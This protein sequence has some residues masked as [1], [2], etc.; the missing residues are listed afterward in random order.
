MASWTAFAT[1]APAASCEGMRGKGVRGRGFYKWVAPYLSPLRSLLRE[2]PFVGLL[3]G[4]RSGHSIPFL[5]SPDQLILL[6]G[7]SF[8]VI[9]GEFSPA[10]AGRAGEPLP[11]AFDLVPIHVLSFTFRF[12][13]V[14]H[15]GA[16]LPPYEFEKF[17]RRRWGEPDPSGLFARRNV[18]SRR[19]ILHL[20]A[21]SCGLS[22]RRGGLRG[23]ARLVHRHKPRHFHKEEHYVAK[24]TSVIGIYEDRTTVSDVI[25]VLHKAGYRAADIS[26]LSSE[27]QGS[28]DFA[29]EKHTKA[30][31]GAGIGAAVG[32]VV[33][34]ALAWFVSNQ[35]VTITGL[36]PLVAAGPLLAALAGAGA[37][38]ALG[39]IVGLLA[40]LRL[41]EY[42]AK[43]YAGRIRRGGILLSVHCDSPEW[44]DRAKKT[45]KDTGARDISSASEAAADYGTTDKPMER[46]PRLITNRGE[47]PAQQPTEYVVH[48]TKQ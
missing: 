29:H 11:L 9:V 44:C 26:V 43:R 10:L 3:F 14:T 37:G 36:G 23:L 46:P 24:N 5:N 4:L 47:A 39:W 33:G 15:T 16:R 27:N 34:A 31:A 8:S 28:K 45:L 40:G 12:P 38:G 19:Q 30:P 1:L 41:T 18:H 2:R 13:G 6:A 17:M 7:D 35:T 48:E 42:V 32:A 20:R 21:L 25:D 22:P